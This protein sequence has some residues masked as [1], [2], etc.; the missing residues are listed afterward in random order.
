MIS[1]LSMILGWVDCGHNYLM[2]SEELLTIL[3]DSLSTAR[4][5]TH[6]SVFSNSEDAK[7]FALS[8]TKNIFPVYPTVNI[9]IYEEEHAEEKEKENANLT[10]L[11]HC[12][13]VTHTTSPLSCIARNIPEILHKSTAKHRGC[14]FG[15]LT[16][17]D[18]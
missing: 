2:P 17:Y 14:Y 3:G 10:E 6:R 11:R 4:E 16:P 9:H 18:F 15:F 1:D 7:L 5:V 13:E 12:V 8:V